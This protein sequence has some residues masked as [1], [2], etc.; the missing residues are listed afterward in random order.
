MGGFPHGTGARQGGRIPTRH[1]RPARWADSHTAPAPGKVGG[2]PHGTGA[3]QGGRISTQHRRP[4][5]WADSQAL[6]QI[7]G[8][9]KLIIPFC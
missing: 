3:R 9:D 8:G 1:R 6:L 4:A 2:F 7:V 5:R